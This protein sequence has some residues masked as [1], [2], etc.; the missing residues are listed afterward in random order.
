MRL[1]AILLGLALA[2]AARAG[3]QTLN[4]KMSGWHSKGDAYKTE[5]VV[6]QV[7]GVKEASADPSRKTLTVV[8]DDKAATESEVMKAITNAG[9]SAQK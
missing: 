2:G 3:D 4:L 1:N 9:Y 5:Q 7:K 6:K 8:Y